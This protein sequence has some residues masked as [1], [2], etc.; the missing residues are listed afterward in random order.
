MS[1]AITTQPTEA[2]KLTTGDKMIPVYLKQAC[3]KYG[4]RMAEFQLDE[5]P[6]DTEVFLVK[7]IKTAKQ[8]KMFVRIETI[9]NGRCRT[10]EVVKVFRN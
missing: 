1:N 7:S 9:L 3:K 4:I 6:E 2:L 8:T 5:Y 10:L